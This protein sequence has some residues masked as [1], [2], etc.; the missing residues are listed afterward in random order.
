LYRPIG[1]EVRPP[2]RR[3][4]AELAGNEEFFFSSVCLMKGRFPESL[5]FLK[6]PTPGRRQ[7]NAKQLELEAR[8]AKI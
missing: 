3:K 7:S 8:M 2:S 4:K 1:R 5:F 6:R